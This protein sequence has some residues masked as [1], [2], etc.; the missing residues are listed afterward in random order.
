MPRPHSQ[1]ASPPVTSAECLPLS[2]RCWPGLVPSALPTCPVL[3]DGTSQHT[4]WGGGDVSCVPIS[5]DQGLH[6]GSKGAGQ[7]EQGPLRPRI[8]KTTPGDYLHSPHHAGVSQQPSVCAGQVLL[9][10]LVASPLQNRTLDPAQD[11][12]S[13]PGTGWEEE[14]G[15]E[16]GAVSIGPYKATLELRGSTLALGRVNCE[17]VLGPHTHSVRA[18]MCLSFLL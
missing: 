14:Q 16:R 2:I 4:S 10:H 15:G 17:L 13:L 12:I 8:I 7:S 9:S 11:M 1:E 6:T 18:L 5:A 3:L